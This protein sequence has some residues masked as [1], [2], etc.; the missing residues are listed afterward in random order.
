MDIEFPGEMVPAEDGGLSVRAL[1]DGE[2]VACQFTVE[3]LEDV[4]PDLTM[5]DREAQFAA[6]K[7][8]L[9]RVAEQKIRAGEVVNGVVQIKSVDVRS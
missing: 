3:A 4:N 5:S 8:Y 7:N 9:L 1:V 6:S 2:T